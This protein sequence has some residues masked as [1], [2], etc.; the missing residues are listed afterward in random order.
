[1]YNI[2]ELETTSNSWQFGNSEPVSCLVL[3]L[4][5]S[6]EVPS[7]FTSAEKDK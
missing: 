2:P 5:V 4:P 3:Y 1:M 6:K 7:H